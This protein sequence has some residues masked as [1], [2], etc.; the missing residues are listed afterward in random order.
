MSGGFNFGAKSTNTPTFG[1]STLSFGT[2]TT[3]N[4]PGFGI[5]AA[6][7]Q[8]SFGAVAPQ[9]Q[10]TF[11]AGLG[12]M[13][14]SQPSTGS[15]QFG[16]AA[17]PTTAASGLFP[18]QSGGLNFKPTGFGAATSQ[19]TGL[20]GSTA[21]SGTTSTGFGLVA[22][23][24]STTS[25]G[26]SF[27]A[28]ASSAPSIGLS[29]G[30]PAASTTSTGLSFGAPAA[31]APSTGLSF[32]APG[33]T[34]T[35]IGVSFGAP[36]ASTAPT[37]I[38]FGAPT[39]P[40]P[41]TGVL[42]GAPASSATSTGLSFGAPAAA[43]TAT[44][45]SFAPASTSAGLTL[46]T[47][48]STASTGTG[49]S[50]RTPAST[51]STGLSFGTTP[52]SSG[53]F[54]S[55]APT[56]SAPSLG[57]SF[58]TSTSSALP[59]LGLGAATTSAGSTGLFG[60]GGTTTAAPSATTTPPVGL[61][62]VPS[63]QTKIVTTQKEVPP[64]DQPLPNEILQTVEQFK[65]MVKHQK[66][67][68]SDIAR[69]S[70]REFRKVEQEIDHLMSLLGDVESQLTKNR[71]LA[72]KLKYDTATCLKN[73]EMAQRTQDTPPGLQ[74]ENTDPLKFFMELADLF[75]RE[76]QVLKYQ[77]ESADNYV[78]NHRSPDALTPQDL[79][80]GMRRL[81]ETFVALAGRLQSVHGQ[82]ESQKEHYRT[83]R[84]QLLNDSS[85]PFEKIAQEANVV[86]KSPTYNIP[87]VATGPT[88]FSNMSLDTGRSIIAQQSQSAAGSSFGTSGQ[89]AMCWCAA[90]RYYST[91]SR[92]VPPIF[93]PLEALM[94][95]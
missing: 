4:L 73:V 53:L 75:E 84:K 65:D 24:A 77:I 30:A 79:A 60:L 69:C 6:Q 35:A 70:V 10:A 66:A 22:P 44:G 82:V 64:K 33:A 76:M 26:L 19:P 28:P 18:A 72:E 8:P 11:G 71:H 89:S 83:L 56:T 48:A 52:Q 21:P 34:T 49:L 50:F 87:K 41:L 37:G 51:A 40:T 80:L 63:A 27:G 93:P 42:F 90:R 12:Q 74:Y 55:T 57:L 16:S 85:D 62:G 23:A 54:G 61:G 20:F 38:S 25:T 67:Y 39:T 81:H 92:C 5:P 68:S 31:S 46:R 94:W 32:G 91:R 88:P 9:P 58:G 7:P 1:S 3:Q 47:P 36:A 29:F 14:A 2:A 43:T 13:S 17:A 59:A 78:K 86:V 15:F 45:L 95:H